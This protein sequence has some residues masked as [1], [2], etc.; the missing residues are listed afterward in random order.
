MLEKMGIGIVKHKVELWVIRK[1]DVE[2]FLSK[3]REK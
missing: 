1:Q 2:C 3:K